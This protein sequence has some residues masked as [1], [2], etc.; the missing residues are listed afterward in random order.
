MWLL[1]NCGSMEDLAK[2]D[3]GREYEGESRGPFMCVCVLGEGAGGLPAQLACNSLEG[4]PLIGVGKTREP[5]KAHPRIVLVRI[6]VL[7]QLAGCPFHG[8]QAELNLAL[9]R[10]PCA[11]Y[12]TK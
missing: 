1:L 5:D 3:S 11:L 2:D 7:L 6:E 4:G 8:L 12:V 9:N 10:Q